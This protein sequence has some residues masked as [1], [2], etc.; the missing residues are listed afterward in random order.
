M[1]L[2]I[3]LPTKNRFLY[4]KESIK[5]ILSIERT[6]FELVISDNSDNN[7]L[8]NWI[9]TSINDP[10]LVYSHTIGSI[11]LS[12]NFQKGIDLAVGE[13][14]CT[15]G[16]DDSV[17]PEILD[18]IDWCLINNVDAVTPKFILDYLWPDLR[19]Q[20]LDNNTNISG[21]LRIKNF[22]NELF[23]LDVK[24]GIK[25][26]TTTCG[27][28]LADTY[29]LPKIYYGI[30]KRT[31]LNSVKI[32]IGTNFP[33]ISPDLS[34]A[35]CVSPLINNY[36][37]LDYPI[38]IPG[39]SINSASGAS[40]LKKHHGHLE[41]QK[42]FDRKAIDNWPDKIPKF[43]SVETVWAQSTYITLSVLGLDKYLCKFNYNRIFATS[44]MFN[45]SYYKFVFRA[46]LSSSKYRND[47]SH[48]IADVFYILY[49]L[50][51]LIILRARYFIRNRI[52]KIISNDIIFSNVNNVNDAQVELTK[53]LKSSRLPLKSLLKNV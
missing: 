33:G 41:D 32:A 13:Y 46:F 53:Y 17:N 31:L 18:L 1:I 11:S 9:L 27:M 48:K 19:S 21:R 3:V 43:Y 16:D 22:S 52:S 25:K 14:I 28:D 26:V 20:K 35:L 42:Q 40:N 50:I 38:F 10:R 34:G 51:Y 24:K 7:E 37:V 23:S 44:L 4:S 30:I 36:F 2:S 6:D 45:S 29:Y 39:S 15:I 5:S 49:Y 8:E 47:D 12:E